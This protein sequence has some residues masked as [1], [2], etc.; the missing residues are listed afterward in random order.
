METQLCIAN[1]R[2]EVPPAPIKT[3]QSN[4]KT[5]GGGVGVRGARIGEGTLARGGGGR[6]PTG[7]RV[8]SV[9]C[10]YIPAKP[11]RRQSPVTSSI[12]YESLEMKHNSGPGST[13]GVRT[14]SGLQFRHGVQ[15]VD[16]FLKIAAVS[17]TRAETMHSFQRRSNIRFKPHK[18]SKPYKP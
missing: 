4:L 17:C 3:A 16:L 15:L 7:K 11:G 14:R 10:L 2:G 1:S 18:S 12:L 5:K 9:Y 13:F 6:K 8:L